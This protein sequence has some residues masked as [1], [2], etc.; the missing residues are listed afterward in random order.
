[1]VGDGGVADRGEGLRERGV[2][3]FAGERGESRD[4]SRL[5]PAETM[6]VTSSAPD[7]HAARGRANLAAL[8]GD[9]EQRL[10][11]RAFGLF[12]AGF[13][14]KGSWP[15]RI[16]TVP[17]ARV[18]AWRSCGTAGGEGERAGFRGGD[19]QREDFVGLGG[20]QLAREGDAASV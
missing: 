4:R 20:D 11:A 2:E 8:G 18:S 15:S 19:A 12:R 16:C 14:L 5:V 3:A 1:M 6:S 9:A 17:S 10:I 13:E 7:R